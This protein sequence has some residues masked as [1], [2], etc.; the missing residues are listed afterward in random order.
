MNIVEKMKLDWNQRAQHHAQFW[1]AT[2]N[3]Q[4]DEDFGQSGETTANALLAAIGDIYQ[5]TW[6]VL[7]I[8]CGIGRVLKPLGKHFQTLIG[9]DVSSSMIA[10]SKIWLSDFPHITTFETSGVDLQ[11]FE[12]QTFNL[13]Y[14]Y[15]AFQHMPKPV[16]EQ[17]LSEINRVLTPDGYLALQLPMGENRDVP[18]EDTIGIRSYTFSEIERKLSDNG[19]AF[20][21]KAPCEETAVQAN[22]PVD[23]G[24]HLIQKIQ[25]KIPE[26]MVEWAPL[27]NP[28]H[29]SSLDIH[30]YETYADDCIKY[31][32]TQE[33]IQTLEFL[34]KRNPE[35]L[36]GWLQLTAFLLEAGSVQ[37]A[38]S[39]LQ[40]LTTL[41]PQYQ[42]GRA[43]LKRLQKIYGGSPN[44]TA[45]LKEHRPDKRAS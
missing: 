22:L 3:Y 16:F 20:L 33:A 8:G 27:P 36:P 13:V 42:E 9:V 29:S 18:I 5:P 31:G 24:F 14:S 6:T 38:I 15:V 4:S 40:E 44:N 34:I 12:D 26:M 30:L 2:E 11:R 32:K 25:S 39:T 7:D 41:H 17:Y 1:I 21:D 28:Q 23:H 45:L 10:Q 43:T 37:Q 19:L 35:H